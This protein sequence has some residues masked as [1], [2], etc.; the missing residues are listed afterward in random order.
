[1]EEAE[2]QR[3]VEK[4]N[5]EG[6]VAKYEEI[7]DN[8]TEE[9][10]EDFYHQAYSQ[11]LDHSGSNVERTLRSFTPRTSKRGNKASTKT[12]A[13]AAIGPPNSVSTEGNYPNINNYAELLL[14]YSRSKQNYETFRHK[15]VGR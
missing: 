6:T 2:M 15:E 14:E 4:K 3:D 8:S 12:S 13:T 10:E 9:E 7:K 1:M 11:E 5:Q